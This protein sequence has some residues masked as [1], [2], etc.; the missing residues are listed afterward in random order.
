MWCSIINGGLFA[1][2]TLFLLGA[3]DLTYR[4]QNAAF[5][6]PRDTYNVV[7]YSFLGLFK[8]VLLVFNLVPLVALLI[9]K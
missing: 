2:A 9:I 3:P 8:V 7:I 1:L 4:L 6:L 5:P